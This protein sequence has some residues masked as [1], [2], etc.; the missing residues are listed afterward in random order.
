[1]ARP[2]LFAPKHTGKENS[3]AKNPAQDDPSREAKV[4]HER[5]AEHRSG[6][7]EAQERND[8]RAHHSQSQ[9]RP[10]PD[11]S[12]AET[13]IV[14]AKYKL[15]ALLGELH[16]FEEAM[17]H[18]WRNESSQM[19]EANRI[20]IAE[21]HARQ[22]RFD[23]HEQK[24][25]AIR[26]QHDADFAQRYMMTTADLIKQHSRLHEHFAQAFGRPQMLSTAQGNLE[27]AIEDCQA[28]SRITVP[29]ELV[30]S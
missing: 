11:T 17:N 4:D 21:V 28:L 8:T 20:A 13:L 23:I 18:R 16:I 26:Q 19:K 24:V 22:L 15:K 2:P 6:E 10:I 12:N 5:V 3:V 27:M 30:T 29:A 14:D 7:V 25:L 9:P 1:M